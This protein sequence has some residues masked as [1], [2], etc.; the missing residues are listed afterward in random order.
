M[1]EK[2]LRWMALLGVLGGLGLTACGE[3]EAEAAAPEPEQPGAPAEVTP[4]DPP[5]AP[6]PAPAA[7]LDAVAKATGFAKYL[8]QETH[9]YVSFFD[10]KGFLDDL[11]E[12]KL[13]KFL[14]AQAAQSGA[15]SW[16]EVRESPEAQMVLS[17][18]AE[19]FFLAVG[20][21]APEQVGNLVAL[22]ESSTRESMKAMIG[23]LD[24]Q[25]SGKEPEGPGGLGMQ[26]GIM[27][28]M[29]GGFLKDPKAGLPIL[30]KTE[31]PPVTL[32]FKISD[33]DIREQVKGIAADGLTQFLQMAGPDGEDF[34]EAASVKVGDTE[35]MGIKIIGEKVA[36]K[37][38]DE[39]REQMS[40]MM[41]AKSVDELVKII[42]QKNIVVLVGTHEDYLIGF[43]GADAGQ[44]QMAASPAESVLARPDLAFMS[45]YADKKLLMVS[46]MSKE[47][48]EITTKESTLLGS[49]AIGIKNGLA[50]AE[51]FGDTQDLEILLDL[52]AEQEKALF[53]MYDYTPAGVVVFREEGLKVEAYGGSNM[54]DVDL[55]A[56]R[57]YASLGESEDV[58]LFANWV[59]NEAYTEKALEYIDSIGQ[60]VYL[61]AK[62]VTKLDIEDG[63]IEQF[64]EGFGLFDERLRPHLV[65]LW[66]ALRGDLVAG[67]GAEGA[68]VVDLKGGLPTVPGVPQVVID[69]GKAPRLGI[70]APAVDKERLANSWERIDKSVEELLKVAS[71]MSGENIPMQRPMSSES[72]DLKTWFFALPFQTDDFVLS[73]SVDNDH[74]YASTSKSF[75]KDIST[76]LADAEVDE[77]QKGAVFK[78]NMVLLNSYLKD[79]VKLLDENAGEIFGDGSPA[80]EDFKQSL[81]MVKQV[82]DGL[83]QLKE[84][85][86]HVRE[87]GGMVRTSLHIKTGE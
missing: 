64:K 46:S 27:M 65:E 71:E 50:G 83:A 82:I 57:Q 66:M 18:F 84:I 1:L 28:S 3:K 24:A 49:M 6:A 36:A 30:S 58:F 53:A 20:A 68:I 77:S 17:L 31:V 39:V 86:G 55:G 11:R 51:S 12:S 5:P 34:A 38:D 40:M 22:N 9:A 10:G 21:G 87:E 19:E 29:F 4:G 43:M 67:L 80:A 76:A 32:G 45:Q 72:N 56:P 85:S 16:D 48:Q 7:D 25:M 41:D 44:L 59:E 33:G 14:E 74:F 69:N 37:M 42:E 70:L 47:L 8:P 78:M 79:W 75:V 35:F 52:V 60:A 62:G 61:G 73:V 15:F 13:L 23:M 63:D 2:R 54:A 81:P 26:E